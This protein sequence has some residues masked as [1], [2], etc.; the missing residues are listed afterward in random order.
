MLKLQ[1]RYI[2]TLSFFV[3]AAFDQVV[4]YLIRH[5]DGFYICN[6][7]ISFGFLLPNYL[8]YP[9]IIGVIV[10]SF[11][12]LWGKINPTKIVLNKW[13][14]TL[15]LAGALANLID[16]LNYGC[17]IDYIDIKIWPFFNLADVFIVGGSIIIVINFTKNKEI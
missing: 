1:K 2:F 14:L 16:R 7:G 11:L 4:K 8:L 3:L 17:V 15:V 10:A 13:G 9:I 12:Y 5:L 6:P